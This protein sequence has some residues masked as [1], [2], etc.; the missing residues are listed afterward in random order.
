M[1]VGTAIYKFT[2]SGGPRAHLRVEDDRNSNQNTHPD[3]VCPW[4]ELGRFR[5]IS[6]QPGVMNL[7]QVYRRQLEILLP[8]S[9]AVTI[10][11]ERF[12]WSTLYALFY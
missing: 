3:R 1:R 6:K 10:Q 7:G 2:L 8:M 11:A 9:T 4:T 12:Y 5:H